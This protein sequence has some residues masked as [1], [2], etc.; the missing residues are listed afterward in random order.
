MKSLY[1]L[2]YY[3]IV[4]QFCANAT[5]EGRAALA[6]PARPGEPAGLRA[7]AHLLL[8]ALAGSDLFTEDGVAGTSTEPQP[9]IAQ[10]EK[11][12]WNK[13]FLSSNRVM[14]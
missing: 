7:A 1:A 10:M 2:T 14:G 12:V 3:Q 8:A 6:G 5:A 9:D 11:E 4:C 13:V